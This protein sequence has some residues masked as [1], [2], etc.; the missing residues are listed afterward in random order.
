MLPSAASAALLRRLHHLLVFT[1]SILEP[2]FHLQQKIQ[3]ARRS[4]QVKLVSR[5]VSSDRRRRSKRR[6]VEKNEGRNTRP[7]MEKKRKAAERGEERR[8]EEKLRRGG[9]RLMYYL[10]WTETSVCTVALVQRPAIF[11]VSVA[12]VL[13]SVKHPII[14]ELDMNFCEYAPSVMIHACSARRIYTRIYFARGTRRTQTPRS[15]RRG[16]YRRWY[17]NRTDI[18]MMKEGFIVPR[19]FR[20]ACSATLRRNNTSA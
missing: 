4:G 1:S 15:E 17:S 18:S 20:L 2:D 6:S 11:T 9:T 14:T 16:L 3:Q 5:V 12:A 13:P 7:E 8:G 10:T 19:G